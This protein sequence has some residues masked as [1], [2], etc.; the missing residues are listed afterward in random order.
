ME[1]FVDLL[2]APLSQPDLPRQLETFFVWPHES[3]A[4]PVESPRSLS[5]SPGL[6][7]ESMGLY[8]EPP[9]RNED[10]S[11]AARRLFP[12]TV[13]V[14]H[15]RSRWL[16]WQMRLLKGPNSGFSATLFEGMLW[17]E[18]CLPLRGMG[19][20]G[21]RLA[22][23]RRTRPSILFADCQARAFALNGPHLWADNPGA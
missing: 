16:V 11:K 9:R 10:V 20:E 17:V 12:T 13:S 18:V 7:L 1:R 21:R 4:L 6:S 5:E 3:L 15:V 8:P 14:P 23:K 22:P 2:A 19:L